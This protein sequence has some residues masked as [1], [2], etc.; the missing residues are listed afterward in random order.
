MS[1]LGEWN[2][3]RVIPNNGYNPDKDIS[4]NSLINKA[5]TW[6][7]GDVSKALNFM[8]EQKYTDYENRQLS[9]QM[10]QPHINEPFF[11]RWYKPRLENMKYAINNT[12]GQMARRAV[13]LGQFFSK[14]NRVRPK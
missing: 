8:R 5:N 10:N 1:S 12:L 14:K 13:R 11:G 9:H 7:G 3:D 4:Y 2:P 6:F